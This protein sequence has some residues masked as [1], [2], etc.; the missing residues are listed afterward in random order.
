MEPSGRNRGN[1]WQ[2]DRPRNGSKRRKP[3]PWVAT[4]CGSE[5][6]VRVDPFVLWMG[7]LS[8]RRKERVEHDQQAAALLHRRALD[9]LQALVGDEFRAARRS[10]TFETT[11]RCVVR[12]RVR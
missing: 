2:M 12:R 10:H 11:G 8:W 5:R 9:F 1:Q 6:M 7:S 3:L 4:S